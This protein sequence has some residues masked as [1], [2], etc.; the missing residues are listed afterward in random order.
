MNDVRSYHKIGRSLAQ[1]NKYDVNIIGFKSK[2]IN[3]AENISLH[4]IYN[5]QRNAFSRIK[6]SWKYYKLY[7]KV[8]PQ[9][10][11]VS[12]PE[13]LLVNYFIRILFGTRILYDVQEN[14]VGN[15]KFGS[16]YNSLIKPL[17]ILGI[18]SVEWISRYFVSG[19]L[20][21]EEV[22]TE[23]LSF[24][25]GKK[26]EVISNKTLLKV[27]YNKETPFKIEL[28]RAVKI[29]YSGTIGKEYGANEAV[30]FCRSLHEINTNIQLL[31]IGYSSDSQH[32]KSLK[33]SIA[34]LPYVQ[35]KG[36]DY[37]VP[38]EEITTELGNADMAIMPYKLNKN[39]NQRIP[40]KFYEC[41]ALRIPMI[42]PDNPY[43]KSILKPY[44]AAI[45][46][47]F[48]RPEPMDFLQKIK[49]KSFYQQLPGQ[50]IF[51]KEEESKLLR[52]ISL[53]NLK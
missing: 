23:Q 3:K 40:T 51:W 47:D 50:N 4:P 49:T 16:T 44:S 6:A 17:L 45:S 28:N 7:L 29:V 11:I 41:L 2:K 43:W 33:Q 9:I 35:L 34:L 48:N 19:Y 1:T 37:I 10:I 5:F 36:G 15:I 27:E 13:L 31:I 46:V 26:Y 20:L 32:L 12:S 8:K 52:F 18:R 14:Y 42:I 53:L 25:H 38:Y 22:Y 24:I 21:A 30:N 39:L